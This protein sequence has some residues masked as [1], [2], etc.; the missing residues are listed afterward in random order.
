MRQ[1]SDLLFQQRFQ[2]D[3]N[4]R[5]PA[6]ALAGLHSRRNL[7][8]AVLSA[9]ADTTGAYFGTDYTTSPAP[10]RP[11]P[12]PLPRV[13]WGKV[14]VGLEA[15]AERLQRGRRG[16]AWTTARFDVAPYISL[17]FALSFLEFTPS[18]RYRYTR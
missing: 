17:P 15:T 7:E 16:E 14:V 11:R 3:F 12:A 18:A 10:A 6:P 5:P 13:G 8:A 1:Y 9:S 4:A 2:D